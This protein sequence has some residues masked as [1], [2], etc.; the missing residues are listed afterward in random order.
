MDFPLSG[1]RRR[2]IIQFF[3][4]G[5]VILKKA[6]ERCSSISIKSPGLELLTR[7][8]GVIFV[9]IVSLVGDAAPTRRANEALTPIIC[10]ALL[11]LPDCFLVFLS[12]RLW[13]R[14][15]GVGT[16]QHGLILSGV[17]SGLECADD[18]VRGNW[19]A[20]ASMDRL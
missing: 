13:I 14:T 18:T 2:S 1:K 6:G 19:F 7:L 17:L 5:F 15:R 16:V 4:P 12:G 8:Y 10:V 20:C 11:L 3:V 9:A